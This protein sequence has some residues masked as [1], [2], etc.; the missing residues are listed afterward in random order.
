MLK[1]LMKFSKP[2]S[3]ICAVIALLLFIPAG[4][5][6]STPTFVFLVVL[7][8][9][10][11]FGGVALLF[12]AHHHANSVRNYFVYEKG[13]HKRIPLCALTAEEVVEK[14]DDFLTTYTDN[15]ASLWCSFPQGLRVRLAKQTSFAPLVAYRMLLVLSD[16]SAF[17]AKAIFAQSDER[18]VA[19]ICRVLA[20]TG[21]RGMA[22]Y[23]F[24]LK[25]GGEASLHTA[26]SFFAKNKELFATR[27]LAFVRRNVHAFDLSD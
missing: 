27:M 11:L 19:Y 3:S 17:E 7:I 26:R 25:K 2:L 6:D 9:V 4:L 14:V 12:L 22:D 10:F 5:A 1:L 15:Y 13:A 20:S 16:L 24:E 8:F 18:T 21:D 23:I